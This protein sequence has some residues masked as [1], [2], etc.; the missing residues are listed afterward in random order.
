MPR[1]LIHPPSEI[2]AAVISEAVSPAL[3]RVSKEL[4]EPLVVQVTVWSSSVTGPKILVGSEGDEAPPKP[5]GEL[6]LSFRETYVE[7]RYLFFGELVLDQEPI[8][9]TGYSGFDLY[10]EARLAEGRVSVKV[11][12]KTNKHNVWRFKGW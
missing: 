9:G 7:G 4:G 12:G 6:R 5:R 11:E 1:E 3:K 2:V 8:P 10:G